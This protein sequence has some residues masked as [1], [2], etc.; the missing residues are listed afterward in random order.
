MCPT[1]MGKVVL[2]MVDREETQ[3]LTEIRMAYLKDEHGELEHG[4][5]E[6]IRRQL[7]EYFARHLG[8]DLH[9]F[10]SVDAQGE[11][12]RPLFCW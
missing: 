6:A 9:V 8:R 2:R 3:A 7:P 4:S 12:R 5:A 1:V 10:V 11:W